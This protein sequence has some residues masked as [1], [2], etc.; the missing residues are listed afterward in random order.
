MTQLQTAVMQTYN[1]KK[2]HMQEL[3]TGRPQENKMNIYFH[4]DAGWQMITPRYNRVRSLIS[5]INRHIYVRIFID[6]FKTIKSK[7]LFFG[8]KKADI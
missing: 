1:R 7:K 6:I 8:V 5:P 3:L 4:T 2:N